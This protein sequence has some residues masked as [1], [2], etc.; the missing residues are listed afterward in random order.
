MAW[1]YK[2]FENTEHPK[3]LQK[4]DSNKEPNVQHTKDVIKD[5]TAFINTLTQKEFATMKVSHCDSR[6]QNARGVVL[7]NKDADPLLAFSSTG[8]W[9]FK[10]LQAAD[11]KGFLENL[12]QLCAFLNGTLTPIEAGYARLTLCDRE[13][14]PARLILFYQSEN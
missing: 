1:T 12:K 2:Y 4:Y 9:K 7:F 3:N 6:D 11:T 14:A 13:G 10:S 8:A 5:V